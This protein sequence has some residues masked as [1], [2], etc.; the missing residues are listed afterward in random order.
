[1]PSGSPEW[2]T[3]G[4]GLRQG[5]R[6][7]AP[8]LEQRVPACLSAHYPTQLPT[9]FAKK[10]ASHPTHPTSRRTLRVA[11]LRTVECRNIVQAFKY[12]DLSRFSSHSV[13]RVVIKPCRT[14][15]PDCK[16]RR[17]RHQPGPALGCLSDGDES[18]Q[19]E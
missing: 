5:G 1:M 6:Q 19:P 4:P 16:P 18:E 2:D 10:V 7:L 15:G 3:E 13:R 11:G 14:V 9:A 8:L 17:S 12:H